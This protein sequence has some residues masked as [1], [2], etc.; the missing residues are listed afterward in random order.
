VSPTSDPSRSASAS[1]VGLLEVVRPFLAADTWSESQR[2]LEQR[3]ELLG[4]RV[5]EIIE[6]VADGLEKAGQTN[7]ARLVR[8]HADLVRRCR[9]KGIAKAFAAMR[10]ANSKEVDLFAISFPEWEQLQVASPDTA[11]RAKLSN[12][13]GRQLYSLYLTKR[14]VSLL[15]WVVLALSDAVDLVQ[16]AASERQ[17]YI[18][19]LWAVA[20]ELPGRNDSHPTNEELDASIQAFT[21]VMAALEPSPP[22]LNGAGYGL[23]LRYE[24]T[25]Q[26]A[27]LREAI[28]LLGLAAEGEPAGSAIRP[29]LLTNLGRAWRASYVRDKEPADLEN[30]VRILRE[31]ADTT[32][33]PGAV[34]AER[35]GDLAL[36]LSDRYEQAHELSD[37]DAAIK[38]YKQAAVETT[39]EF[40]VPLDRFFQLGITLSEEYQRTADRTILLRA[41]D[42]FESLVKAIR[43]RP[44]DPE[45]RAACLY[46]SGL[47]LAA[48]YRCFREANDLTL[49]VTQLEEAVKLRPNP[50][51][52]HG[53]GSLLLEQYLVTQDSATL[54]HAADVSQKAI[55]KAPLHPEADPVVHGAAMGLRGQVLRRRYE[56]DHSLP[57]L[58]DA[59]DSLEAAATLDVEH[60]PAHLNTLTV[61]LLYRY[62]RDHAVADLDRAT[63]FAQESAR[64]VSDASPNRA[65]V[66]DNLAR[67]RKARYERTTARE[68]LQQAIQSYRD[69][70]QVSSGTDPERALV[71]ARN[72]LVWAMDRSSWMEAAEASDHA[73]LAAER[74]YR[75]QLFLSG[76]DVWLTRS[77]GLAAAGAYALV[78]KGR[79]DEAVVALERDR[80][81][82]L[83]EALERDSALLETVAA[84]ARP[85]LLEQYRQAADLWNHLRTADFA[86]SAIDTIGR[87]EPLRK[88]HAA[89]E[90]SIAAIRQIPGCETFLEAPGIADI[91]AACREAQLVY[92]LATKWGGCSLIVPRGGIGPIASV[93]LPTLTES[94]LLERLQG[95]DRVNPSSYLMTYSASRDNPEDRDALARWFGALEATT[96][97]LW[98]IMGPIVTALNSGEPAILIPTGW[99]GLLPLHAA[100]VEDSARPT[101]RCYAM[102]LVP[103]RYAP[104]ARILLTPPATPE[105]GRPE[106]LLVVQE[107][108]PVSGRPLPNADGE[109]AVAGSHFRDVIQLP[110]EKALRDEVLRLLPGCAVAHFACHGSA[111]FEAPLESGLVMANDDLLTVRQILDV[112]IKKARLAVLSACEAGIPGPR[113]PDQVIGLP[114]GFLQAGF[115]GVIA[116]LWFVDDS[117]TAM[118]MVRFYTNWRGTDHLAPA[119]A[120]LR[121][122][123]WVR[124]TTNA[125][126]ALYFRDE[127]A[128]SSSSS[129]HQLSH[130][131]KALCAELDAKP[132]GKRD[133]ANPFFWAGFQY[134]GS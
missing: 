76:T 54:D 106:T 46:Y 53:L 87:I 29:Q 41:S 66:M 37:L 97:W 108:Q 119:D 105:H 130:F 15:R 43:T 6:E 92:V 33:A 44:V 82:S 114:A 133:Y 80:A 74:L 60:R 110:H 2:L 88:A 47:T 96:Q 107:P 3:P 112:H 91:R 31:A 95:I 109:A 20:T 64:A 123:A 71:S 4:E 35:F 117:S 69:A 36:A 11:N 13:L 22:V 58:T 34:R 38:A 85:D 59:I 113:L 131:V 79:T 115:T 86:P 104:N 90:A 30:A 28:R 120:L 49:A 121:A 9:A 94:N 98:E 42:V 55:S 48:R 17:S 52:L 134:V 124:D 27:D 50:V 40:L 77:Q 67:C 118:L 56:R 65:V 93:L 5:P 129:S 73:A 111:N 25:G 126:K 102:D 8:R 24:R 10:A 61:A 68:D 26:A 116:P 127:V 122:Q 19:D 78:Q 14:D 103:F 21:N 81:R 83:S 75:S 132:P 72:W 101:G 45:S 99:L 57:D 18:G 51:R 128:R 125:E 89:L 16:P 63:K 23:L 39:G 7:S 62:E 84:L 70:V 32:P 1:R 100:W 12:R